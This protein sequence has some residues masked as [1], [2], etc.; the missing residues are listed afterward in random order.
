MKDVVIA[1]EAKQSRDNEIFSGLLRRRSSSQWR[2]V[3]YKLW[4]HHPTA[5]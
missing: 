2:C 3:V 1:S 4:A 5:L